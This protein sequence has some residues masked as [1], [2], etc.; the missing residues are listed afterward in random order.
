M[1]RGAIMNSGAVTPADPVTAPQAQTIYDT[2][3]ENAGCSGAADTL[4]CLRSKDYTTF[5]NAANSVPGIF[6]Y[7]SLDLSYLPRP[8]PGDN[9]FSQS[10]EVSLSNGKFT[11]VPI[12]IGDQ[13]DEGTLFSLVQSNITTNAELI[14]Y[15]ASYFPNSP[16]AVQ[17]VTGLVANY[18]D[19][20]LAGQPAGSPFGTGAL[21]NIYPQFKRLAAILGDITF[22]LARRNYL[23][24][25][26]SQVKSWSYLNSYLQ[27]LP[28]LGTLHGSD[29]LYDYGTLGELQEPTQTT[30]TYY[31]NFINHLDPNGQSGGT[32]SLINWPQ[33]TTASPSL[34]NF[35]KATNVIIQDTF[36]L[37]ASKYL[38]TKGSQLRV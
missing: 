31:I 36:R 6:S 5:L 1:F 32:S 12:I 8:D 18:P 25:V 15:L 19:Q 4:E 29:I 3:V 20:A 7:R 38:G 9:F 11:K 24:V 17:V 13:E 35:R 16:N 22:T 28:V 26:S 33:Y 34:V 37:K 10:P 30:Q 21:Y 14:T 23:N 27:G 2:V